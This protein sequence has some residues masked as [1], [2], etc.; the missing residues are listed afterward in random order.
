M[1]SEFLVSI[2][3]F[4][5]SMVLMLFPPK[6]INRFYGYRTK[7]SM[8]NI[9]NWNFSNHFASIA[10]FVISVGN[11]IG[12]CVASLFV[13]GVNKIVFAVILLAELG[14]VFLITERKLSEY[15][16]ISK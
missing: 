7:K 6:R 3:L 14:L 5:V 12:F 2:L 8:K 4:V 15:E 11:I 16:K 10:I 13:D 9:E 1:Y